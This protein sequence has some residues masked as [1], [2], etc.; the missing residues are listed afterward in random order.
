MP[1]ALLMLFCGLMMV[2]TTLAAALVI[3]LMTWAAALA[4]S[5]LAVLLA[6]WMADRI[7]FDKHENLLEK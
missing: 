5:V 2:G 3:T 1:M 4:A 6:M 7:L